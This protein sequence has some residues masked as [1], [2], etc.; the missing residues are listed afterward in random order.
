MVGTCKGEITGKKTRVNHLFVVVWLFVTR[1]D[2]PYRDKVPKPRYHENLKPQM[3]PFLHLSP[4]HGQVTHPI[5]P[6]YQ[7]FV[8]TCIYLLKILPCQHLRSLAAYSKYS[9]VR[10]GEEPPGKESSYS[11][12][13][14]Q[15]SKVVLQI[16]TVLN[17]VVMEE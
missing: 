13:I 4:R 9:N 5:P 10:L 7:H 1:S 8:P 12:I 17:R 15:M 14:K 2:A 6:L 3:Y 16:S 11:T